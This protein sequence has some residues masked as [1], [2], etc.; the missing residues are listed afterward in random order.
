MNHLCT[1][2]EK[3]ELFDLHEWV[4]PEALDIIIGALPL[5][6]EPYV[7]KAIFEHFGEKFN[8]DEIRW[9]VAEFRRRQN[10]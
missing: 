8:Y 3:G 7:L 10:A 9:A 4:S 5:F 6:E 2:Y 1:M